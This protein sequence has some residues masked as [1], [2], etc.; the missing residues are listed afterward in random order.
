MLVCVSIT[1]FQIGLVIGLAQLDQVDPCS[2]ALTVRLVE[3]SNA[4]NV[5]LRYLLIA[6]PHNG[7]GRPPATTLTRLSVNIISAPC[8]WLVHDAWTRAK[9]CMAGACECKTVFVLAP[10]KQSPRAVRMPA[11]FLN[12]I[13]GLFRQSKQKALRMSANE[14]HNR[15][16]VG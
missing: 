15:V 11:P 1:L 14:R 2:C 4:T 13:C 12:S 10:R 7:Q 5:S 8:P 6:L 3:T 16:L 9:G